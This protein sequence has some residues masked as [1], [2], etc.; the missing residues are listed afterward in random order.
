MVHVCY[1]SGTTLIDIRII[2][3]D[4]TQIKGVDI[5][6]SRPI[7]AVLH[8]FTAQRNAAAAA[9]ENRFFFLTL[10]TQHDRPSR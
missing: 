5:S 10:G 1:L 9:H 6:T 7:Y 4:G 3:T 8:T 2:E